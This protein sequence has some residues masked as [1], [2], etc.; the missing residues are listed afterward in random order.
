MKAIVA[1]GNHYVVQVKGNQPTLHRQLQ[2]QLVEQLP[3][4]EWQEEDRDH[5]RHTNWFVSVYDASIIPVAAE[6]KNLTRFIQVHRVSYDTKSKGTIH[7][8]RLY[9]T[10]LATTNA[11]L[12][13][14]GIRAHWGIENKL[15]Y[16]KDVFH[17]EDDN[18]IKAKNGPVNCSTISSL[19]INIHRRN[20]YQSIKNG[21]AD[22][23]ANTAKF[24]ELFKT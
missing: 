15:H 23:Q 2:E 5:G 21:Q 1:S 10:D 19:A 12:Y 3:L 11:Q 18:R 17:N 20:G 24:I 13:A 8:D 14:E 7:A 6:W 9:I 16:V 22:A 4:D